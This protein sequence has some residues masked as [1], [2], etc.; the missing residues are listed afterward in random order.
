MIHI[1]TIFPARL[2]IIKYIKGIFCCLL[3]LKNYLHGS[4]ILLCTKL[5][6]ACD[7]FNVY[8]LY[9][10]KARESS[11][12]YYSLRETVGLEGRVVSGS[13]LIPLQY[14]FDDLVYVKRS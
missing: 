1:F 10:V 7:I 5:K 9:K 4:H 11:S 3:E 8:K 12:H 13:D 6:R 14:V 2:W